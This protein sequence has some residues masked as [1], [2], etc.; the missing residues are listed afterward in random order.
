MSEFLDLNLIWFF[1]LG[2][3]LIGYTILDGFDLGVGTLHLFS[4]GDIERRT[5]MNSIGPVWDGNE[6]WLVTG[7]GALFA[8]FPHAYA[9]AFSAF[10]LPFIFLVFMLIFRACALEFRSKVHS[11]A[12]QRVWDVA[13]CLSSTVASLLF[14]VALG[15]MIL[16]MRIGAD[17]E[18]V[19]G[20]L[21]L[22]HPYALLVGVF[23]VS[24]FTMHGSVYL[25]MKTEG[26]LQAKIKRW[27]P[28]TF[29]FF[30]IM[31]IFTTMA[32]LVLVPSMVHNFEIFPWMWIVVVLNV[33]AIANIPRALYKGFEARAFISS[34]CTI[35]ALFMLFGVGVYPN[36]IVSSLD[37]AYN[38][39]IYNAASSQKTLGIMLVIALLGMPVVVAYTVAIYYI[40]RGKVKLDQYSY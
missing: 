17:M 23:A 16:G 19:G 2:V 20:L 9:T 22:L 28:R 21:E 29:S 15:N 3:L 31:Y 14:G 18:Y 38:L 39:T 27:I 33:L 1:L 37:P 30:V 6:V 26:E 13:F 24:L 8:A 7:G 25:Y 40:F 10:Y 34:C 11:R 32:T 12:W 5:F 35:A 36:M 4:R